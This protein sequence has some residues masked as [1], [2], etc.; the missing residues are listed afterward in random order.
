[1][2]DSFLAH[3]GTSGFSVAQILPPAIVAALP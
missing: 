2:A 3:P 1:V